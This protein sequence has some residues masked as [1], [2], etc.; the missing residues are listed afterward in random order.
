MNR[1]IAGLLLA[2]AALTGGP[3]GADGVDHPRRVHRVWHG[4]SLRLPRERH[5]IEIVDNLGR[6]TIGGRVFTP[7]VPAC[8]GWIAG[9]RVRFVAIDFPG[10]CRTAV[11]YNY[12]EHRTCEV[13]CPRGWLAW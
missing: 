6:L 13:A 1:V 12:E 7:I 11:I 9:Q 5:V 4:Y 2:A 10:S 8:G 3:A